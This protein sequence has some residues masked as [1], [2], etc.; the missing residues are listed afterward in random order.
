MEN[1]LNKNYKLLRNKYIAYIY[2][3]NNS[4]N[5]FKILYENYFKIFKSKLYF[6]LLMLKNFQEI[7]Y[8]FY[9]S[10]Y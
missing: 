3:Y 10:Q 6:L 8:K 5:D 4:K 1:N 9:I 7:T 2:F